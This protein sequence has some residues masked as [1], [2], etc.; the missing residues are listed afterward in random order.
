ME[1]KLIESKIIDYKN[2]LLIIKKNLISSGYKFNDTSNVITKPDKEINDKL[3]ILENG[4]G[5]LPVTLVI[6]FKNIGS[7]DFSGHHDDWN[8]CEYPNP[9]IIEPVDSA[10]GELEMWLESKEED[11]DF[12]DPF[13]F[14]I[15]PDYYHKENVSGGMFYNIE[16]PTNIEDPIISAERHNVSFLNYLEININY[17]CFTGL[18]MDSETHNCPIT[19]IKKGI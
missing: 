7:I 14:P 9:L 16:F 1:I 3:E 13:H 8:G 19:M 4:I 2:K 15:A 5:P 6:F 12:N 18:E 10:I 11:N 17:G